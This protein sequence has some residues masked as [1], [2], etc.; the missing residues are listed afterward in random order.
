MK[1]LLVFLLCLL[2]S[3]S[4][5]AQNNLTGLYKGVGGE[6]Y[7]SIKEKRGE[8][9]GVIYEKN[10]K[11]WHLEG[12]ITN[13]K[14]T[15]GVWINAVVERPFEGNLEDDTLRLAIKIPNDSTYASVS[16]AF[17]KTSNNPRI[18][19]DQL[20]NTDSE[21]PNE[22]VGTWVQIDLK[23]KREIGHVF[24]KSGFMETVGHPVSNNS[25][26]INW[27]WWVKNGY[28]YTQLEI[29]GFNKNIPVVKSSYQLEGDKLTINWKNT[30]TNTEVFYRKIE[31]KK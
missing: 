17:K 31:T 24:Q 11:P 10:K 21:H 18:N 13:G 3:T 9:E 14:I 25:A 8:I 4:T 2:P 29:L 15:G 30:G 19:P 27:S 1:T 6:S 20:F 5:W 23:S 7:L 12:K 22:L 16:L 28:L 26:I